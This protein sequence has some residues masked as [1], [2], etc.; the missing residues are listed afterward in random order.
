MRKQIAD[1]NQYKIVLGDGCT[2]V[3]RRVGNPQQRATQINLA[4]NEG[5]LILSFVYWPL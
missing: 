3:D 2:L 4:W 5:Y 1:V